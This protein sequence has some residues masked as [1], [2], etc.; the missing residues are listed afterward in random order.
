[1]QVSII[2]P[3]YNTKEYLE[4]C[5]QSV[6]LSD[7]TDCEV[8]LVDD[9]STDGV[10]GALCDRIA[11]ENSSI[12]KVIHQEN[13]G[14]GGARN[15]GIEAATGEYLFFLDSDDWLMPKAI[16]RLK[17]VVAEFNA[18]VISFNMRTDDGNGNGE[19]FCLNAAKKDTAFTLEEQPE[20]LLSLPNAWGRLWKRKL[21]MESGVRFPGRA[22]YEDIRT[23]SKLF[24]VAGSIVT[25]DDVLYNYYQRE[26]SI[27][28]SSNIERNIEIVDAFKDIIGWFKDNGLFERYKDMLCGLCIEHLYIVASVRVLRADVKHPLLQTFAEYIQEE[29]PQYKKNFMVTRLPL[30]RKLAFYLLEMKQYK[31]IKLLFDIKDRG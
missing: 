31:L 16:D 12:I 24:A 27:M 14:L 4:K 20:F 30:A 9:G 10:S 15:T 25:I 1:M 8:I 5:V 3:V 2:I 11:A 28:R 29:F 22:W 13:Q 17:A 23:T 21:F 18:D 7:L 6:F 26:G 19:T